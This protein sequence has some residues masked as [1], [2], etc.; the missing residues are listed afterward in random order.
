[1][2]SSVSEGGRKGHGP[3]QPLISGEQNAGR[4]PAADKVEEEHQYGEH[5]EC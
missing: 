3:G 4:D 1:M 5:G 2:R